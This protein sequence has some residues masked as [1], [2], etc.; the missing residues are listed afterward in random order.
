MFSAL[1]GVKIKKRDRTELSAGSESWL[2]K[3]WRRTD[4]FARWRL[5]SF[6]SSTSVSNTTRT[7]PLERWIAATVSVLYCEN[8]HIGPSPNPHPPQQ[9]HTSKHFVLC[10]RLGLAG[11][12]SI[13]QGSLRSSLDFISFV[14]LQTS[15][16]QRTTE[17]IQQTDLTTHESRYD[18]WFPQTTKLHTHDGTLRAHT[19]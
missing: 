13:T 19:H 11:R 17:T 16:R 8:A 9:T 2:L 15:G 4:V 5:G 14:V 6:H 1:E 7:L 3:R 10:W 18:L 12:S